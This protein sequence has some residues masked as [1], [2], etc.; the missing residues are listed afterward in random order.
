ML[1]PEARLMYPVWVVLGLVPAYW[2]GWRI[3]AVS[4]TFWEVLGVVGMVLVA[5]VAMELWRRV[6]P[7]SA[8]ALAALVCVLFLARRRWLAGTRTSR[9]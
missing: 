6:R 2:F 1:T 8:L 9:R 3:G 4:L 5:I 7:L